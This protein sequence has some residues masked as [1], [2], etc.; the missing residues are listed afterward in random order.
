V[1]KAAQKMQNVDMSLRLPNLN[2]NPEHGIINLPE[3]HRT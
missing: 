2:L 3:L 1:R